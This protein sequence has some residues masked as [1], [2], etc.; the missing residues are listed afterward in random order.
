M[1]LEETNPIVDGVKIRA[2]DV[3][4]SLNEQNTKWSTS[5][6]CTWEPEVIPFN[7]ADQFM[8]PGLYKYVFNDIV[9]TQQY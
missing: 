1:N 3:A 8:Y 6:S 5:S 2:K 7:G 4:L 9:D